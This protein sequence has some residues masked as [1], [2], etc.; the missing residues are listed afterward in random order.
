MSN[1]AVE[2]LLENGAASP[3]RLIAP[4]NKF[5]LNKL[6]KFSCLMVAVPL[7]VLFV[8]MYVLLPCTRFLPS[9]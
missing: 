3:F 7:S 8:F 5:V 6:V 2:N 4:G 1:K 9:S